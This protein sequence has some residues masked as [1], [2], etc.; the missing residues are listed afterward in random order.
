[1]G[2]IGSGNRLRTGARQKSDTLLDLHISYFRRHGLLEPGR[3]GNLT[4]ATNGVC[5]GSIAIVAHDNSM[6]LIY[7]YREPTQREW[8][9]VREHIP[10]DLTE[11]HFGGERRWFVCLSCQRRCAVLYAGEQFRC[12]VCLNLAYRSQSEDPRY[13]SLSKARKLRQRLGGSANMLQP[14]PD[15]PK[16]THWRTYDRLYVEGM[17][18]EQAG[19]R[20]LA[21]VCDKLRG[22]RR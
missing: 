11:Q 2:G 18:L 22:R 4:W 8:R 19:L 20:A 1:M 6:E 7:R 21:R 10:L 15:K 14:F 9:S 17:A 16:G 5:S 12:R 13:R 3:R